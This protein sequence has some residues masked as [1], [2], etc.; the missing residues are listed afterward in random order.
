MTHYY[1]RYEGSTPEPPCVEGVHWRVLKDPVKVAPSQLAD[2]RS[3]LANRVDPVTCSPYTA[4]R[5]EADGSVHANRPLQLRR[6][7][8]LLVFC[9]CVDWEPSLSTDQVFCTLPPEERG[10]V[11]RSKEPT[12]VPNTTPVPTMD[13]AIS[14][15]CSSEKSQYLCQ[16]FQHI[17]PNRS[18]VCP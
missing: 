2:L 16:L 13:K 10:V 4:A 12:P 18:P 17:F 9:E 3:L 11:T 6:P 7:S 15:E 8:H 5:M 1:F 14:C